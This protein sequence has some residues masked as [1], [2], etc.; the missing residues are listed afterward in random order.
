[1]AEEIGKVECKTIGKE[2][3]RASYLGNIQRN[4]ECRQ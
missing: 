2:R 1:M 3:A 4:R